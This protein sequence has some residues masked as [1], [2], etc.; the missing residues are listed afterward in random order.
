MEPND[1]WNGRG[2]DD[3]HEEEDAVRVASYKHYRDAAEKRHARQ[4]QHA[5]YWH[6]ATHGGTQTADLDIVVQVEKAVGGN[7]EVANPAKPSVPSVD[8]L[9]R[10]VACESNGVKAFSS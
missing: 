10:C 7:K 2:H 6:G 1:D 4:G 9:V 3:V 5:K 8:T